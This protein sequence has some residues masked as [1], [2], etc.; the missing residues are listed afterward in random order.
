[1]NNN[2]DSL[3]KAAEN[4]DEHEKPID[5]KK[6]STIINNRGENE[7]NMD[8]SEHMLVD[9]KRDKVEIQWVKEI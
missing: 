4:L 6:S 7:E 8:V 1:M 5:F 2:K 3:S 9:R